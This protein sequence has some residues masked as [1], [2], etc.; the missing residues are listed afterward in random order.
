MAYREKVWNANVLTDLL[1][2]YMSHKAGEREK[3]YDAALKKSPSERKTLTDAL[4]YKRYIDTGE[5]VFP[6]VT[7]PEVIKKRDRATD[8]EGY[9]R[10]IDTGERVFKGVTKPEP[11]KERQT[12][13]DV[14]GYLRYT[15][16]GD[17][18]FP[19]AKKPTKKRDT[20]TDA[21]G[22]LRYIDT[23]DRVFP[24]SKKPT[25]KR[26][27]ATDVEGYLRYTDTGDRVLPESKKPEITKNRE[28]KKDVEGYL[29]YTD[30]GDRVFPEAKKPAEQEKQPEFQEIPKDDG[31]KIYGRWMGSSYKQT[32]KDIKHGMEPGYKFISHYDDPNKSA[33]DNWSDRKKA[34]ITHARKEINRYKAIKSREAGG[35]S[36]FATGSTPVPY[37]P[38]T[39]GKA[40]EFFQGV[41][42]NPDKWMGANTGLPIFNIDDIGDEQ[43]K[44]IPE[45]SGYNEEYGDL[46]GMPQA[47]E[48]EHRGSVTDNL[49]Y[50]PKNIQTQVQTELGDDVLLVLK[51]RK[52]ETW[53]LAV[54]GEEEQGR[55]IVKGPGGYYYSIPVKSEEL[56]DTYRALEEM[57]KQFNVGDTSRTIQHKESGKT[58]K[59]HSGSF[60]K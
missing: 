14:E 7:K 54:Q 47:T 49:S 17:R 24:E 48:Q 52:H 15:D 38:E 20:K 4:G 19:E 8:A 22:Y 51:G 34:V 55:K 32:D 56:D 5:K 41:I 11:T 40:L 53:D 2:T 16:T 25:K 23:G 9:M 57:E 3:Y 45:G 59:V 33:K 18:V 28:S 12:K 50:L 27:T 42:E 1:S 36:S 10:Y 21:E 37:N 39:H 35:F 31:S 46:I 60:W 26:D 44:F 30:T 6:G 13:T 29:R 43:T 58:F